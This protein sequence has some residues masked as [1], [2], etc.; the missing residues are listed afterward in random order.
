MDLKLIRTQQIVR[1]RNP[2]SF[3][4]LSPKSVGLR[5]IAKHH[6]TCVQTVLTKSALHKLKVLQLL[7]VGHIQ[8]RQQLLIQHLLIN[9]QELILGSVNVDHGR[10]Y[11]VFLWL[12]RNKVREILGDG[13]RLPLFSSIFVLVSANP[14]FGFSRGLFWLGL[15]LVEKGGTGSWFGWLRLLD[16]LGMGH[17]PLVIKLLK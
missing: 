4:E 15:F 17:V 2:F 10:N 9:L 7:V 14:A 12:S 1:E 11:V 8:L 13:C 3:Q 5:Y 6:V 16:F